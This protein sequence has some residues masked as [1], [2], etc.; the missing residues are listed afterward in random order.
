MTKTQNNRGLD[1][2]EVSSSLI[3]NSKLLWQL[4]LQKSSSLSQ[5]FWDSDDDCPKSC[6]SAILRALAS[7]A[8]SKEVH[9]HIHIPASEKGTEAAPPAFKGHQEVTQV[10]SAYVVMTRTTC[11]ME[12][13]LSAR[14]AEK[15]HLYSVGVCPQ[16]KFRGSASEDDGER[17]HCET[18]SD[19]HHRVVFNFLKILFLK[20]YK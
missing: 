5:A 10:T 17:R 1:S 12:L 16:W 19:L 6:C 14:E 18:T 4:C 15:C 20:F 2:L 3:W 7:S 11:H 9:L 8:R 13:F